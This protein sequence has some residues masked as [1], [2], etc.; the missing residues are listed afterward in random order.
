V[1]VAWV[2]GALRGRALAGRRL[3]DEGVQALASKA[4]LGDALTFLSA[5]SYGHR[6]RMDL[7]VAGARRAVAE[8][9]L[10]HLRVLAGWLPARG[11]QALRAVAGWFE[12]L[13]IQS[14][15]WAIAAGGR[16]EEPAFPLG[17]LATIWP[18]VAP[19]T[20]LQELRVVLAH[21]TWG[22]PGGDRLPDI[23]L[24]LRLGWSRALRAVVPAARAWGDGALTLALARTRFPT[25]STPAADTPSRVPELGNEWRRT[26]DLA[27]FARAMP[28]SGRWVLRD[29]HEPADL[30]QGERSWWTRVDREAAQ[31]VR[32]PELGRTVVLAAA[33]LLVTDCWRTQAALEQAARQSASKDDGD[34][35]A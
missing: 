19:T 14:H 3:G 24:G 31:M 21:S 7:D 6:V 16:W 9:S 1:S 15:A 17:A 8:T 26:R 27:A 5:S 20:T 18:R 2:A 12:L 29:V 11:V 23:L 25:P 35:G 30:W 10:W 28:P 34:A 4:S 13:D 22:D 33:T 32:E